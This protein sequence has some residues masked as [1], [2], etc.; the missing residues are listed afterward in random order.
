MGTGNEKKILLVDNVKT[1]L[2]REKTMLNR[3]DFMVYT[4][5]S[6]EEALEM[7]TRENMDA[8]IIDQHMPGISGLEVCKKIRNNDELRHVSLIIALLSVDE[9]AVNRCISAGANACLKKPLIKDELLDTLARFLDVPRRQS[10]RIIVRIKIDAKVGSDFF[11]ANT[12]DVSSTGLL[13]ECDRDLA[14]GD[15]V[16]A[17]FF[18]PG[19]DGF[20]QIVTRCEIMRAVPAGNGSGQLRYGVKFVDFEKGVEQDIAAF[21]KGKSNGS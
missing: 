16:E 7:H 1:I 9:D 3:K 11:I 4:A 15:N 17:S 2:E 19:K 8:I 10:I 13:F 20:K 12:V 5:T 14:V 18:L 6:G 21:V